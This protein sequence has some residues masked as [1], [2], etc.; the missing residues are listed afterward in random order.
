MQRFSSPT[1]SAP[2][3]LIAAGL[4]LWG[5]VHAAGAYRYNYHPGRALFVLGAVLGFLAFWFSLLLWRTRRPR[6]KLPGRQEAASE[7]A[8][9]AEEP[10]GP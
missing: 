10:P 3:L 7:G 2:V 9:G 5:I 6:R 4:L 1:N 8:S